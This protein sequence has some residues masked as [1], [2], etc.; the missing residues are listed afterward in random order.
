M[1]NQ[2][3]AAGDHGNS[4]P[5]VVLLIDNYD[6]YTHILAHLVASVTGRLPVVVPNDAHASW[7][8]RRSGAPGSLCDDRLAT[9]VYPFRVSFTVSFRIDAPRKK[10]TN[11]LLCNTVH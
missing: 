5:Q 2:A 3:G 9:T 7:E 6:S 11:P 8:S 1:A 10:C 4:G